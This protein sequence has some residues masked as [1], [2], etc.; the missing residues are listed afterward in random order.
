MDSGT[1]AHLKLHK[2]PDGYRRFGTSFRSSIG[3]DA[4]WCLLLWSGDNSRPGLKV[5]PGACLAILADVRSY[6]AGSAR[7]EG[8]GGDL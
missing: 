5:V 3:I 1:E 6:P 2:Q 8:S 7:S 4:A